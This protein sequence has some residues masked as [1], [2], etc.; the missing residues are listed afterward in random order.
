M[1]KLFI[2]GGVLCSIA[3]MDL[4]AGQP[5]NDNGKAQALSAYS[6]SINDTTPKKKGDTTS[7]K[8]DSAAF[9]YN[10]ASYDTTPKKRD[11]T[12]KKK[13][14]ASFALLAKN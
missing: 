1:K 8:K 10:T 11:T 7:K 13:D 5:A 9:A 2:I 4:F 14:T 3:A 6:T 12:S